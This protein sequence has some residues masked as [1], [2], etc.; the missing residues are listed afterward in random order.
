MTSKSTTTIQEENWNLPSNFDLFSTHEIRKIYLPKTSS[1]SSSSS[2]LQSSSNNSYDSSLSSMSYF[3]I[4]CIEPSSPLDILNTSISDMEKYDATGHCVW[5]GAFLLIDCMNLILDIIDTYHISQRHYDDN[6]YHSCRSQNL[7]MIELG[8]G[9]GI[10]GLALMIA[11]TSQESH[12]KPQMKK[13]HISKCHFT[14]TDPDV[15]KVCKRNCKLNDLVEGK[16]YDIHELTWGIIES[17]KQNMYIQDKKFDIILATDVLYDIDLLPP[18]FTTVCNLLSNK[19]N[20]NSNNETSDNNKNIGGIFILSHIPRACYNDNNPPEAIENL[21]QYIIDQGKKKYG[22]ELIDLVR[23]IK[24]SASSSNGI[25][26]FPDS[27][28][29]FIF[30]QSSNNS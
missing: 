29:I 4:E 11:S 23:P 1:S 8:C 30:C 21:E 5:T 6:D 17:N 15:L 28:A 22:L 19:N 3:N 24:S 14:D 7:K 12:S 18:L 16:S 25:T 10:G 9:T 20:N 26:S 27:S 2:S 13:M